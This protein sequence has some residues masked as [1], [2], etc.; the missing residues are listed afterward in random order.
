MPRGLDVEIRG[1][2]CPKSGLTSSGTRPHLENAVGS[3]SARS[4]LHS[5]NSDPGNNVALN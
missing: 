1:E 4:L 5:D 2:G 3:R